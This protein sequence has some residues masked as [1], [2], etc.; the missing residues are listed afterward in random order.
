MKNNIRI[1]KIECTWPLHQNDQCYIDIMCEN[2]GLKN[3]MYQDKNK[4]KSTTTH[5]NYN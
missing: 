3:N 2:R 5:R 4:D 1:M